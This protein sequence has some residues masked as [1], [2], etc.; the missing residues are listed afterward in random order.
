MNIKTVLEEKI[1]LLI[2]SAKI[3]ECKG[4]SHSP[5]FMGNCLSTSHMS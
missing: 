1:V 2:A 4:A 3:P 5:A